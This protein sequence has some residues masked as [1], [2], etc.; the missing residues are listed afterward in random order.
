MVGC[1]LEAQRTLPSRSPSNSATRGLRRRTH[2]S[3]HPGGQT[4]LRWTLVHGPC[5]ASCPS[6]DKAQQEKPRYQIQRFSATWRS[7][8]LRQPSRTMS[9]IEAKG[10]LGCQK[11]GFR[12]R[13][14]ATD[15]RAICSNHR[16]LLLLQT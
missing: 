3:H 4:T 12:P 1:E 10:D 11:G 2:Q 14:P 16:T 9:P 8:I 5:A 15:A 7:V 13:Q 6:S